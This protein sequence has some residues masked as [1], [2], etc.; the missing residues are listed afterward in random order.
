MDSQHKPLILRVG[1]WWEG[2]SHERRRL[3]KTDTLIDLSRDKALSEFR[4][5]QRSQWQT[6]MEWKR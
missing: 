4:A 5:R 3:A 6:A 1:S 2:N